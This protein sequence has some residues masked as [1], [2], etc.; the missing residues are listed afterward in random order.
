MPDT[1]NYLI[2]GYAIS[3]S[4]LGLIVSSIWWRFRSLQADERALQSIE[5]E[6]QA[7]EAAPQQSGQPVHAN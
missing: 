4:I 2:G 6:V 7:E 1:V 5:A 3:F